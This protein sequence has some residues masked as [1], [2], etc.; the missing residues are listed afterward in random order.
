MLA[1]E[2]PFRPYW[3]GVSMADVGVS[4]R[5]DVGT[6]GRYEFPELPPVPFA[7]TGDL[8]WLAEQPMHDEWCVGTKPVAELPTLLGA[9]ERLGLS[10]P[11]AFLIFMRTPDLQRRVRSCTACFIDVD[12]APVRAPAGDGYLLRF[13]ADQQGCLFWYL[14]LTADGSDHAVVCSGD[15]Y[16]STSD[17]DEDGH[18]NDPDEIAFCGE[19]FETFLCRYWLENEIGFANDDEAVMP[20]GA[21]EYISR[22]RELPASGS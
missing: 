14:Y 9:C 5:P 2:S 13:L 15:E 22:Y 11:P 1:Q 21:A 17:G 12:V 19:S 8:A 10:L 16:D 3:W 4:C 20:D 7:M 6:Y 18:D